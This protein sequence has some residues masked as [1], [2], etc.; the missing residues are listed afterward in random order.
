MKCRDVL[1]KIHLFVRTV[2]V[3]A[4]ERSLGLFLTPLFSPLAA[5]LAWRE[6]RKAT[7]PQ[8]KECVKLANVIF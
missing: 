8:S 7:Q 4:K 1:Q 2:S 6:F 5:K 3:L